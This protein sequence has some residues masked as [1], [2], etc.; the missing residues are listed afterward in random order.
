MGHPMRSS[1]DEF[2][3]PLRPSSQGSRTAI[4]SS[5]GLGI[6]HDPERLPWAS[7]D[8]DEP[9]AD[10][11]LLSAI[12]REAR[13]ENQPRFPEVGEHFADCVLV[14][15]LGQGTGGRVFLASQ[16]ELGDRLIVLK[17]TP[18]RGGEHLS[19]ARL[20]HTHIVPLLF[21]RDMPEVGL[22]LLAMPY[23]GGT[24]L[25]QV[26]DELRRRKLPFSGRNVVDI[27]ALAGADLPGPA[28]SRTLHE[29]LT[30]LDAPT[31][32]A[33]LGA[34]VADALAHAHE[35]G[36]MH[37]DVKPGNV[38]L[39]ADGLP[40]LLDF[41]LSQAEIS[42]GRAPPESF[43]G[44]QAYMAPEQR[45]AGE[46]FQRKHNS[47]VAV[48]GRADLYALGVM[49]FEML[50]GER[51]DEA[52]ERERTDASVHL[53]D[54]AR[55][56]G[57]R[58]H[59][60]LER[61][62]LRRAGASVGLSDIIAK[63]MDPE[64]AKRYPSAALLA[65]DLRRHLA[66]LPL[67]GVANRSLRERWRKWRLR[68]PG[69]PAR[70]G[71]SVL[72]ALALVV[73]LVVV[74]GSITEK[75]RA[76]SEVIE[77]GRRLRARG[78]QAGAV[79]LL[80]M[81]PRPYG[82]PG[83]ARWAGRLDAERD[84]ARAED[85]DQRTRLGRAGLAIELARLAQDLRL[86]WDLGRLNA[87]QARQLEQRCARLW[88]RRKEL[89]T[90]PLSRDQR[91]ELIEVVLVLSALEKNPARLDEADATLGKEEAI[92][93]ERSRVRSS[94][95][96]VGLVAGRATAWQNYWAGRALLR[97][98]RP[99]EAI[100]L[101][102]AAGAERPD[103]VWPCFYRG[104]CATR[105]GRHA[106]AERAFRVCEAL[107]PRSAEIRV[108]RASA[109]MAMGMPMEARRCLDRAITLQPGL[110][111]AWSQRGVL[112]AR[113]GKRAEAIADLEHALETGAPAGPTHYNLAVLYHEAKDD[114]RAR[115]H[116]RSA[117]EMDPEDAEALRLRRA[118][119][120]KK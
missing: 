90:V 36:L 63:C 4:D 76:V 2:T 70:L 55:L 40:L 27:L 24:S 91:D 9:F 15:G 23:V 106:E 115:V 54:F 30:P 14:A 1:P 113:E 5:D 41:H 99:A 120:H 86:G 116:L 65:D 35:R 22:R 43:G 71:M 38:L 94:V 74:G 93:A 103:A 29:R 47:P 45:V 72:V 20:F 79:R 75:Q 48:D 10:R 33:W 3:A 112:N 16:V 85:L 105:L 44:T 56:E 95:V 108:D 13:E 98:G 68:N 12:G 50:V 6:E 64:P 104:V 59:E 49:L 61:A 32:A 34:C 57:V 21:A 117:L 39:A 66:G 97:A 87:A 107:L 17:V 101:F 102:S 7:N 82:W 83:A 25:L 110:G 96:P 19:L 28:G 26:R 51:P 31:F 119:E 109:L 69:T 11:E 88:D 118:I 53:S 80:E 67:R 100:P 77:E 78:D 92:D 42:V 58:P 60:A 8:G 52:H 111:P 18:F 114:A 73:G 46:A 81:T 37:L 84:A 89:A 62:L